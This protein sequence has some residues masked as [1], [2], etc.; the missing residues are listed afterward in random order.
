MGYQE[1]SLSY[2][3]T[4]PWCAVMFYQQNEITLFSSVLGLFGFLAG[5]AETYRVIWIYQGRFG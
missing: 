3:K 4:V 2:I 1:S 5:H